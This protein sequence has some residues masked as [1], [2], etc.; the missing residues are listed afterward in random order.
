MTKSSKST[1]KFAAPVIGA[2]TFAAMA[3]IDGLRL[4]GASKNRVATLRASDLSPEERRAEVIRA[5]ADKGR[6]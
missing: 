3:A 5:Y 4:E 2:E 1:G 6:R